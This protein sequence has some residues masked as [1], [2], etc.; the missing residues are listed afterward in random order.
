MTDFNKDGNIIL[1]AVQYNDVMTVVHDGMTTGQKIS[2]S[3]AKKA[4]K[5]TPPILPGRT[6]ARAGPGGAIMT[7]CL[8][9]CGKRW[10]R[11][12]SQVLHCRGRS[13]CCR[14]NGI[15]YFNNADMA[16][17]PNVDRAHNQVVEDF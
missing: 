16:K 12:R 6:T 7:C 13:I 3:T 1:H 4:D 8:R 15:V 5:T 17:G 2:A 14:G 9:K 11:C 10:R